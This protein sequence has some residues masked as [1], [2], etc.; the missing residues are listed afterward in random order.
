MGLNKI[1]H[2]CIDSAVML[3]SWDYVVFMRCI[4]MVKGTIIK[5]WYNIKMQNER[6]QHGC[7]GI[8][9][10]MMCHICI[11]SAVMLC[12]WDYVVFMRC[13]KMAKETII[14]W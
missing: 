9:L 1:C 5:R 2:L 12:S 11:D 8:G 10:N 7:K 3:C 6:Q 4:K 14:K 13:I